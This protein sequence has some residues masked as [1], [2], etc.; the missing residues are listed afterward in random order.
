MTDRE[1]L[2]SAAKAAGYYLEFQ[3]GWNGMPDLATIN[4]NVWA[5]LTNFSDRYRLM[6]SLKICVNFHTCYAWHRPIVGQLIQE[7]WDDN[8]NDGEAHAILLVA[9]AIGAEK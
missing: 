4:G 9:A 1:L 6:Q 5:P 8:D 3:D 2:E 7:S